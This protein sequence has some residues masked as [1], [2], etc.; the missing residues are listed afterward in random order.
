MDINAWRRFRTK[1]MNDAGRKKSDTDCR[2]DELKKS[3]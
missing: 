3:H 1:K 2:S